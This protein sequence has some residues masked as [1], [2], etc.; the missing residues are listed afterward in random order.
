MGAGKSRIG[1][2]LAAEYGWIFYDS[3]SLIE[4]R[5][6]QTVNEIFTRQG[7]A[8]FRKLETE[9]IRQLAAK[10]WPSVIALGGGALMAAQSFNTIKKSGLLIYIK[11]SPEKIYERIKNSS[12]RPLLKQ[13]ARKEMLI[14][15]R[16]L[17]N[18]R[19]PVY[20]QADIIFER[21]GLN[22]DEIVKNLYNQINRFWQK[23]NGE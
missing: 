2:T 13:A 16:N 23:Q 18:E 10:P 9:V 12:K 15:I 6:A 19:A 1:R 7:E 21:D 22:L 11:S 4:E 5:S 3:D 20:E 8:A 17:L 14:R